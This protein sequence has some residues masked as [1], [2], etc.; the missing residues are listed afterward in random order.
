MFMIANDRNTTIDYVAFVRKY[1]NIRMGYTHI[2][3]Y[4]VHIN[5]ACPGVTV[6]GKNFFGKIPSR[7]AEYLNLPN[8]ELY[9][10]HCFRNTSTE[11][12]S[13]AGNA[14]MSLSLPEVYK[15]KNSCATSISVNRSNQVRVPGPMPIEVV[16]IEPD[17]IM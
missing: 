6:V 2:Q 7:I 10:G 4:F 12:Q 1:N 15:P 14:L 11:L 9:T 17:L 13:G 16:K 8:H 5:N 3:R